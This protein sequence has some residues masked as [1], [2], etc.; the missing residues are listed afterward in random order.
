[1]SCCSIFF[2]NIH[3]ANRINSHLSHLPSWLIEI[4]FD[5]ASFLL[6]FPFR[7]N[8]LFTVSVSL[9]RGQIRSTK[10]SQAQGIGYHRH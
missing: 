3:F 4:A 2:I 9:C 5:N 8:I 7:A 1:V 6:R 10:P